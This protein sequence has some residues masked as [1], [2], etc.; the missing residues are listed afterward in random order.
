MLLLRNK[1]EIMHAA[2]V[3]FVEVKIEFVGIK[4]TF[5]RLKVNILGWALNAERSFF[6][7]INFEMVNVK[8]VMQK[9]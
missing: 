2:Y 6:K 1:D 7:Y 4:K 8:L 3:F 9:N 5:W